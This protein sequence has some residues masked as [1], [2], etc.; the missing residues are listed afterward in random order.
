MDLLDKIYE[1]Q[2]LV[3][4]MIELAYLRFVVKN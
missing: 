4:L 2:F 3:G 1:E